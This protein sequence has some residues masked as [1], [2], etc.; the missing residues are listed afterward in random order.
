MDFDDRKRIFLEVLPEEEFIDRRIETAEMIEPE[1]DSSND[2][3]RFVDE[4][5]K[6]GVLMSKDNP[7]KLRT[8]TEF[9]KTKSYTSGFR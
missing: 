9:N 5:D 8:M 1:S 4:Y 7:K 2:N 6:T 3:I